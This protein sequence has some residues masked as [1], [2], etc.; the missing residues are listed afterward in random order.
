MGLPEYRRACSVSQ[1]R[2]DPRLSNHWCKKKPQLLRARLSTERC[3][4]GDLLRVLGAY[5]YPNYFPL[6]IT[7]DMSGR[8]GSREETGDLQAWLDG[9]HALD[10][11]TEGMPEATIDPCWRS[12]MLIQVLLR[13][14]QASPTHTFV[15]LDRYARFFGRFDYN[16]IRHYT[17]RVV[18]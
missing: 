11:T 15:Y 17:P 13:G 8:I 4:T 10:D 18:V 1:V 2:Y 3:G 9:D 12:N 14:G 7:G 6:T 16:Q 5:T